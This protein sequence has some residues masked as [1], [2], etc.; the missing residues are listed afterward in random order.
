MN[1]NSKQIRELGIAGALGAVLGL[2][3]YVELVHTESIWIRDALAGVA[4]GGS[5]GFFLSGS[6][7]FRDRAF[8]MFS[9]A[10]TLGAFAGA[11]GRAIGLIAGELILA[12]FQGGLIGRA[13][14]WSVMGLGIGAGQ[15]IIGRSRQKLIFGLIGGGIGGFVGGFLFEAVRDVF[16]NR[17]D[18]GQ[19]IGITI[20]G[21]GLGICLA[22][23]EQTLRKAWIVVLNGRQEGRTYSLIRQ[24][25]MLGLDEHVEVGLF[26][27]M[28][29]ARKHASIESG[30]SG[31]HIR[32]QTGV[33]KVNG[34]VVNGTASLSDG[35]LIELGNTRL[36]FRRR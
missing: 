9:R 30:S 17:Y 25:S 33:T 29:V 32:N 8:L 26:G 3:L 18:L 14:S 5:I 2:F 13:V 10:S 15:G 31:F 20:L 12:G 21:A 24:V 35:D 6:T 28:S 27:D 36:T 4:I 34:I 16:S 11:I 22:F 1:T 19:G 23:V 7:P